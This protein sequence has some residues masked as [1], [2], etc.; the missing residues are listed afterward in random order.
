MYELLDHAD[1]KSM[2]PI[3]MLLISGKVK[4]THQVKLIPREELDGIHYI[5]IVL[6]NIS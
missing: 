4:D 3:V 5:L 6:F 1:L 2:N